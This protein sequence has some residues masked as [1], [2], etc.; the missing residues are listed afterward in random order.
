M[1][2]RAHTSSSVRGDG[3]FCRVGARGS[4]QV[5]FEYGIVI[6]PNCDDAASYIK[7]KS[8]VVPSLAA[9]GIM[10]GYHRSNPLGSYAARCSRHGDGSFGSTFVT[11]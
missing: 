1:A 7:R 4:S 10:S 8:Q 11:Y 3:R 2:F 5:G 6:K 9:G